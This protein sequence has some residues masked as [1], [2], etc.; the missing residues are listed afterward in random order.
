MRRLALQ[1]FST[2]NARAGVSVWPASA[3][4][5]DPCR[6]RP[7]HRRSRT[8]N[9]QNLQLVLLKPRS[10][11]WQ[12]P[13]TRDKLYDIISFVRTAKADIACISDVKILNPEGDQ[14]S[15][16][17]IDER[18]FIHSESTGLL[19][20]PACRVAFQ[21]GGSKVYAGSGRSL[22]IKLEFPAGDFAVGTFFF[23]DRSCSGD[24]RWELTNVLSFSSHWQFHGTFLRI[25]EVLGMGTLWERPWR[26]R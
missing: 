15:H 5:R 9:V 2:A 20:G 24:A 1:D 10:L 18:L 19:L 6:I 16:V 17:L 3:S 25:L 11:A 14:I 22:L 4:G 12:R 26:G 21:N 7:W 8:L 23:P 13:T